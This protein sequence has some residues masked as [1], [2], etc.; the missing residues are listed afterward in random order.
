VG[1]EQF[2]ESNAKPER[3]TAVVL[4]TSNQGGAYELAA[5]LAA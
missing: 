3:P 1:A 5:T 2:F 4:A